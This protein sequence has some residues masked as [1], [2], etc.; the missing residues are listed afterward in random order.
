MATE[1]VLPVLGDGIDGGTLVKVLVGE[2]DSVEENQPVLEL[3][4]DKAVLEVPSTVSGTVGKIA[5]KEGAKI[6]IGETIFSVEENSNGAG[7]TPAAEEATPEPAKT[8]APEEKQVQETTPATSAPATA[9]AESRS[10]STP[11]V[12]T[13]APKAE[14]EIVA[15]S[16]EP[17]GRQQSE[18]EPV[19]AAPSTRR[20]AREIGLDIHD[21]SG[22]GPGGRISQ[23]DVKNRAREIL[24][25]GG[26]VQAGSTPAVPLP[27]FSQFGEI[28]AQEFSNVRRATSNQM[29]RSWQAP[30]VTQFD[31]AD[32]TE[33]EKLRKKYAPLAEESG[34][35]LTVT[36][37]LV[38]A[39]VG[40][41][42]KFP[43]FNSSLDLG[44][45]QLILKKYYNI[46][47]A[48][49]T[50]RGLL[51]PVIKNADRKGVFEIAKELGEV[52][53]RARNKKTGLEELQG[54]CFTLTNLGG[55]GGTNFTPIVNAPEVAILGVARGGFEP[56]WNKEKNEFEPRMMLP[57][58][59]SYDHRVIDG[60]DGA[61][62]LRFIAQSLQ[63]P[64]LL[65]MES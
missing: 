34:G 19:P 8:E 40:A 50:E 5:V 26:A 16:R 54:G 43:Q 6:K 31:K 7:S 18:Y 2:G 17:S 42:K 37:I 20:F 28:E 60:A 52:A 3:E 35:K 63:E 23:D 27:D 30:H 13:A 21:V 53:E 64:F 48:V 15:P 62:F 11:A 45:E 12:D 58:S 33:L 32:I 51:V 36:A 57:L 56:V 4:T 47:V 1:F 25:S 55:I 29:A 38:K 41:L 49:D 24:S 44:S 65:A 46:G 61:R 22:S 14:S 10:G 9:P 59:L 39:I